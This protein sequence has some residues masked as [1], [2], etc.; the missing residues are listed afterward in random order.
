VRQGEA[1]IDLTL[2]WIA[3]GRE[4]ENHTTADRALVGV[5]DSLSVTSLRNASPSI[6]E[7]RRGDAAVRAARELEGAT[8]DCDHRSE[9]I[10]Q[11]AH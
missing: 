11:S 2:V 1:W 3:R 6:T 8:S 9:M 10:P 7:E 5:P 4:A